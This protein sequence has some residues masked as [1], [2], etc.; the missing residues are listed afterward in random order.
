MVSTTGVKL[1][2]AFFSPFVNRVQIAFNLKSVDFDYVEETLNSKS[3]LLLD[4]NPV[5]RKVP[6]VIHDGKIICESLIIVQYIDQVW[7]D[8]GYFILPSDPSDRAV[9]RFW[10]GYIDDKV[11]FLRFSYYVHVQCQSLLKFVELVTLVVFV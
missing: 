2:G 10:A 8:N 5:H 7:T 3:N 11:R 4:S 6:V 1:I 9:A